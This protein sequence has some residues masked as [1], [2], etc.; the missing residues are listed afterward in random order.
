MATV[1]ICLLGLLLAVYIS[2]SLAQQ[3]ACSAANKKC[4]AT[5]ECCSKC[6]LGTK[7]VDANQCAPKCPAD[8]EF[9]CKSAAQ[10]CF[11][12]PVANCAKPPCKPEHACRY[13]PPCNRLSCPKGKHCVDIGGTPP[14][15]ACSPDPKPPTS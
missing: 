15:A 7:C 4:A 6:C 5:G 9:K 12:K 1:K 10:E 3:Q 2:Q 14:T 11:L 8:V 13:V